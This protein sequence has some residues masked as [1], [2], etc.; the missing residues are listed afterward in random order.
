MSETSQKKPKSEEKKV[1][2]VDTLL[3][4]RKKKRWSVKKVAKLLNLDSSIIEAIEAREFSLIPSVFICGY[5]R[6]Y[7][8]I[9]GLE[10]Q[11]LVDEYKHTYQKVPDLHRAQFVENIVSSNA[12]NRAPSFNALLPVVVF[13][14]LLMLGAV[15]YSDIA[16]LLKNASQIE[17]SIIENDDSLINDE[18]HKESLQLPQI[19]LETSE[20]KQAQLPTEQGAEN[21]MAIN[22]PTENQTKNDAPEVAMATELLQNTQDLAQTTEDATISDPENSQ[23][24]QLSTTEKMTSDQSVV[25]QKKT[26]ELEFQEECWTKIVDADNNRLLFGLIKKNSH[27]RLKATPPVTIFLGNAIG[28][29]ILVDDVPYV[30]EPHISSDNIARITLE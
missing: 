22:Q 12:T 18:E 28:V 1:D 16:L 20:Q 27:Y 21:N 2:F 13:A 5:I 25:V 14:I 6:N 26:L 23:T 7:A 8:R 3:K 19:M 9:L 24:E 17:Q 15:F 30:L 29:S 4:E 10:A 11:H